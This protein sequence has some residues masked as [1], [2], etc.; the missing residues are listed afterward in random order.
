MFLS[1]I[2]ARMLVNNLF[3][4][5]NNLFT[6]QIVKKKCIGVINSIFESIC[7]IRS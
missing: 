6:K 1:A 3:I 7:G 4:T 2:T 5:A